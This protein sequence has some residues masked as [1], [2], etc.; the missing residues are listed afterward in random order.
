MLIDARLAVSVYAREL[1]IC[2]TA[3]K[4]GLHYRTRLP[5]LCISCPN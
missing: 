1:L 5:M 4:N 2:R 3:S